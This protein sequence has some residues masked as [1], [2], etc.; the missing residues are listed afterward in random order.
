MRASKRRRM[1]NPSCGCRAALLAFSSSI[2]IFCRSGGRLCDNEL[3]ILM[4]ARTC[5]KHE[6]V[7]V[8]EQRKEFAP[9]DNVDV[10]AGVPHTV[11]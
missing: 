7:G 11:S 8:R 9:D 5:F 3:C 2:A 4:Y 10:F 6:T 1:R